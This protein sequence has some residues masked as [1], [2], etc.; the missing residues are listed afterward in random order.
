MAPRSFTRS[1]GLRLS[2][3]ALA[4][5]AS[6]VGG[7][8]V[9]ATPAFGEDA[10]PDASAA[11][12]VARGPESMASLSSIVHAGESVHVEGSGWGP[13]TEQIRGFVIITLDDGET[14]RPDGME[15]P[16]WVPGAV[17]RDRTAWAVADVASDGTV[18]TDI[19]LPSSWEVGPAHMVYIGDAVTG[20]YVEAKVRVVDAAVD[21]RVCTLNADDPEPSDPDYTVVTPGTPREE[22]PSAPAGNDPDE[23][24]SM[25]AQPA[26]PADEPKVTTSEVR[27]EQASDAQGST[28]SST[29]ASAPSASA[30][31]GSSHPGSALSRGYV[32]GGSSQPGASTPDPSS[33]TEQQSVSASEI[34]PKSRSEQQAMEQA[35]REQEGRLNGWILAGGGALAL[36]GAVA[37]VSIV[38]K[39]HGSFH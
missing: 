7:V 31:A 11:C 10:L 32:N 24:A 20:T 1:E 9:S 26:T 5:S 3:L 19:P 21:I 39:S 27:G 15:L 33:S 29:D 12:L 6:I 13:G 35:A 14:K 23:A 22:T 38:R 28:S 4:A 17:R 37:T 18:S 16:S 34:G 2:L 25:V 8:F 36:L 30:S